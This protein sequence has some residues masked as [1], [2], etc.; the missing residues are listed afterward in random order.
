M[1]WQSSREIKE[2]FEEGQQ[3]FP[4]NSGRFKVLGSFLSGTYSGVPG[5][6]L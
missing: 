5:R 3:M 2:D 1:L 4:Q 6:I